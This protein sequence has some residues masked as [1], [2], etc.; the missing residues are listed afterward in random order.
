MEI[1]LLSLF[2]RSDRRYYTA[3]YELNQQKHSVSLKTDNEKEAWERWHK[4]AR[5]Y[6]EDNILVV[7]KINLDLALN[8]FILSRDK[9]IQESTKVSDKYRINF[10][11]NYFKK[12]NIID[13]S[14]LDES[15]IDNFF[16]NLNNKDLSNKTINNYVTVLNMFFK[17][18]EE[19]K[20]IRIIFNLKKFWKKR[21]KEK[22]KIIDIKEARFIIEK[23]KEIQNI[24]IKTFLLFPF[25]TGLRHSEVRGLNRK[26]IDFKNRIISVCEK[27]TVGNKKPISLLKSKA[28]YRKVPIMKEFEVYLK[29]Y[30]DF[31]KNEYP[32]ISMSNDATMWHISKLNKDHKTAYNFH[33]GRHFFASLLIDNKFS[34]KEIQTILG[35]ENIS[36]TLDTYG[37]LIREWDIKKFDDIDF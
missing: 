26:N 19:K 28:A 25:F 18:C 33:Q 9:T 11:R 37:H 1:R 31:N 23:I 13:T 22:I 3:E 27:M 17:F 14:Q 32:F 16:S 36:T 7:K 2:K 30:L 20:Y 5:F 15:F 24:K 34:M 35:H 12:N 8:E 21:K 10:F 29:E 4:I 6:D